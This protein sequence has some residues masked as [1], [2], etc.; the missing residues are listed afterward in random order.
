MDHLEPIPLWTLVANIKQKISYGQGKI[1]T[2]YGT[3]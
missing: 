3:K 2:R 1:E